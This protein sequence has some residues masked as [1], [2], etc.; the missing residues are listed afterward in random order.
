GAIWYSTGSTTFN[1]ASPGFEVATEAPENV[2]NLGPVSVQGGTLVADAPISVS[3]LVVDATSG[4]TLDGFAFAENGTLTVKNLP[5]GNE[6]VASPGTYANCTGLD[7][8]SRWTLSLDGEPTKKR[9]SVSGGVIRIF[10]PGTAIV[11]R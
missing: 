7:G 5:D 2:V 9:I 3:N 10:S 11:I 6:M 4:G 1:A 8:V